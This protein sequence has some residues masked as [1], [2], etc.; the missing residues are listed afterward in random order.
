M[1]VSF[2]SV[3]ATT[4]SRPFFGAEPIRLLYMTGRH[5]NP[6]DELRLPYNRPDIADDWE[7]QHK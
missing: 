4:S 6:A 1:K 5:Y 7:R 2:R 3:H